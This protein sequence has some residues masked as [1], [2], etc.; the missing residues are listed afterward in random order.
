M[1]GSARIGMMALVAFFAVGLVI[2]LRTPYP[3]HRPR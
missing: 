1:T 3:A 2:L